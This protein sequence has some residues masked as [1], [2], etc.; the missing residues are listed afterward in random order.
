MTD[1]SEQN[2]KWF[3]I[4]LGLFLL[5]TLLFFKNAWVCDDAF[6]I[7]RSI[8]QLFAGNGPNWNPHERVQAYTSPLWFWVLAA[9]RVFSADHFF[10]VIMVSFVAFLIFFMLLYR[11]FGAGSSLATFLLVAAGSSAFIDF[12]TSGLENAIAYLTV[13]TAFIF[14]LLSLKGDISDDQRRKCYLRSLL[15]FALVPLCRHDL[16]TLTF[17][18]SMALIF[19]QSSGG[20][21]QRLFDFALMMA[22]LFI[23]SLFSLVYYG[24]VFPN[25]A[26]AKI[27][28]GI[29]RLEMCTQGLWYIW[30]TL[31]HDPVTIL[32]FITAVIVAF[33]SAGKLEKAMA[34]GILFN[35]LYVIFVGGDFMR[36][37]FFSVA[38]PVA[39]IL[40]ADSKIFVKLYDARTALAR[41]GIAIFLAFLVMFP[42]TPVNTGLAYQNFAL[43]HGIADERGYYFDVC[44]LYAYLYC[45]PGEVFPDFEWSH[46]GR[47]IAAS[48]VNYLE[49]DFNGMLGYWAG[50]KPVIIDRLALSDPFL[51]RQ[52]VQNAKNWRIGHFKRFVSEDYRRSIETGINSFKDP[53]QAFLYDMLAL[54]VKDKQLFSVRRAWAVVKLNLGLY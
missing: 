53:K 15:A 8:E 45:P 12:T 23:W 27:S 36:G 10:N 44:S 42:N 1:A 49:N 32:T 29:D 25:T 19:L 35:V 38:F 47:Q 18:P 37:R 30:V 46:I 17:V 2:K 39:L 9:M 48:G 7:F 22:P 14:G 28:T 4:C 54:A 33:S 26:Y 52:P 21:R 5:L 13:S 50:T 51:A 24:A 41:T 40:L 43:D 20:R 31:N 6:I 11:Y 3:W 34:A 16:L